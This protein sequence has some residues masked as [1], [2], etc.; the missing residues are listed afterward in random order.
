[1]DAWFWK[2]T[3]WK[4]WRRLRSIHGLQAERAVAADGG[5]TSWFEGI[6]ST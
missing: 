1:M 4:R 5:P 3:R 6:T 2:Q